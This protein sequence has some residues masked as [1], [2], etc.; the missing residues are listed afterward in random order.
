MSGLPKMIIKQAG[1]IVRVFLPGV[2]KFWCSG[3]AEKLYT[4]K[5]HRH[6]AE[7]TD[8]RSNAQRRK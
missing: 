7:N 1:I 8:T 2:N 3:A 4:H 5:D 6:A